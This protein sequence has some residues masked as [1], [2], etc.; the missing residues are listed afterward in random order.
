MGINIFLANQVAL[1]ELEKGNEAK[2]LRILR[3][4]A[5]SYPSECT[6]N[7][8]GVYYCQYGMLLE[9][10][11][12][13]SALKVG[14]RYLLKAAKYNNHMCFSNIATAW[15]ELGENKSAYDCFSK[16]YEISGD[17]IA[18]YNMCVCLFRMKQYKQAIEF[19]RP[20]TDSFCTKSII[21]QGG[22]SPDILLAY[23]HFYCGNINS[24]MEIVRKQI[25]SNQYVSRHDIFHLLFLCGKY[26]EALC[27][28]KR[29]F[30]E[31]FPTL[32]LIAMVAE[33]VSQTGIDI[34]KDIPQDRLRLWNNLLKN[35]EYRAKNI[36]TYT[37]VPANICMYRFI[38]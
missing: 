26:K 17:I 19:L 6:L 22:Q 32:Y 29:L 1:S 31:W 30:D 18:Q 24:C 35:D 34:Q 11:D 7:N 21:N 2:A 13:R 36:N 14:L 4:N 5:K 8:L 38:C 37:Y 9:N 15:M 25:E 33:C 3:K 27:E 16:A 28:C 12:I 10:G 23:S 20:L